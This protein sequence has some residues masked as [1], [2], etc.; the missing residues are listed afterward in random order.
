MKAQIISTS[1]T[2]QI[3]D[4]LIE[5]T[6]D[7]QDQ[8]LII[9][10]EPGHCIVRKIRN[11]RMNANPINIIDTGIIYYEQLIKERRKKNRSDNLTI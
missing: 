11:Y 4:D 9:S 2:I 8:T 5:M 7:H 10:V 6:F 1:H 3:N